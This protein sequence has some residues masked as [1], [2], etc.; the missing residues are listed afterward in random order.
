MSEIPQVLEQSLE[1]LAEKLE[2][3]VEQLLELAVTGVRVEGVIGLV[4]CA[5]ML[6]LI[7]FLAR[8]VH[9]IY[10]EYGAKGEVFIVMLV[11]LIVMMLI[12]MPI[13]TYISALRSFAP[14]YWIL[15][16]ALLGVGL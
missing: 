11:A 8:K 15:K 6:V 16:Q 4:F 13:L 1:I 7:L 2:T 12:V 5:I 9:C 3:P 14:E 10:K